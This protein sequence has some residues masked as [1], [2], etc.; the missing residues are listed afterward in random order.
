MGLD[1]GGGRLH[2]EPFRVRELIS[3]MN[4]VLRRAGKNQA[5]TTINYQD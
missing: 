1:L 5:E 4:S 3:R 2:H